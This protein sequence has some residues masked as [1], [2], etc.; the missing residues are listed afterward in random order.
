MHLEANAWQMLCEVINTGMTKNRY[1]SLTGIA[2][3]SVMDNNIPKS[4]SKQVL[5][6]PGVK[7]YAVQ[8]P[9]THFIK[10]LTRHTE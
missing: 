9:D 2:A 1:T 8:T 7:S 3:R 5:K 10:W 4:K 6:T